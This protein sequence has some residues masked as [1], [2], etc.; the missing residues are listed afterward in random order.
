M[1]GNGN[2]LADRSGWRSLDAKLARPLFLRVTRDENTG[3][4]Q[5]AQVQFL[6]TKYLTR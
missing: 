4:I 1:D 6:G 5:V 3:Q 2:K